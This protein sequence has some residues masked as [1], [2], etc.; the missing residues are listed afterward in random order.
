MGDA[1][2]Y[3]AIGILDKYRDEFEHYITQK[4]SRFDGNLE[5]P[6]HA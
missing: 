5:V 2:G 3:A 1:A 4:R 6:A